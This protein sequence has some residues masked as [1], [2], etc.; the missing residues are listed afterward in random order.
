[1]DIARRMEE[2]AQPILDKHGGSE[3]LLQ[4][5]HVGH[6][7]EHGEEHGYKERPDDF[8]N[9]RVYNVDFWPTYVLLES[10]CAITK[11]SENIP[12]YKPGH[13]GT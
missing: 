8:F 9:L 2:D 3:K 7:M 5:L 4:L 12:Q 1:M 10:F 6:C 13:Y 11:C